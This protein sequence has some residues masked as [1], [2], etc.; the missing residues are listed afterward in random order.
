MLPIGM[1]LGLKYPRER[2]FIPFLHFHAAELDF[3]EQHN[4]NRM[5]GHAPTTQHTACYR[6]A[7]CRI[8]LQQYDYLKWWC[9]ARKN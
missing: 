1:V 6:T 5:D 8:R 9:G 2:M 7:T 3:N 4:K